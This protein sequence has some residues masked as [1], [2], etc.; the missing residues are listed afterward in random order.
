MKISR[1]RLKQ[2][3]KEELEAL[4]ITKNDNKSLA[5]NENPDKTGAARST[6]LGKPAPVV[7]ADP[8]RPGTFKADDSEE[9]EAKDKEARA[10]VQDFQKDVAEF[11]TRE[12]SAR[13]LAALK[14]LVPDMDPQKIGALMDSE[15]EDTAEKMD[16]P[17]D[18]LTVRRVKRR[19]KL[20]G[21]SINAKWR[22]GEFGPYEGG[23]KGT[24]SHANWLR[25]RRALANKGQDD[26]QIAL[27]SVAAKVHGVDAAGNLSA[28][29]AR[30]AGIPKAAS[31]TRAV[32]KAPKGAPLFDPKNPE[33][34]AQAGG[35]AKPTGLASVGVKKPEAAVAKAPTKKAT[36]KRSLSNMTQTELD[37]TRRE[38]A[39]GD[40]PTDENARRIY[41]AQV[42]KRM[43][44][45]RKERPN[46]SDFQRRELA[47]IAARKDVMKAASRMIAAKNRQ[48][49]DRARTNMVTG[50]DLE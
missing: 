10:I 41:N 19:G 31:K 14:R 49:R 16:F 33:L 25:V 3:I 18:K 26:A 2:I 21:R 5:L 8:S 39:A 34:A 36:R 22:A 47:K 9:R 38:L 23:K 6:G 15:D 1:E 43:A 7:V 4:A 28:K 50:V 44:K 37:S 11:G 27:N 30:V 45:L 29:A 40:L 17:A 48:E 42:R 12:P 13:E 24:K 46:L 32:A 20:T 35:E